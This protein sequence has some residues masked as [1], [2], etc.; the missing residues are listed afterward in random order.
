MTVNATPRE[1][2]MELEDRVTR[3][4]KRLRRQN[5]QA[6]LAAFAMG[7]V[8]LA[9]SAWAM[10]GGGAVSGG[11]DDGLV[12]ARQFVLQDAEGRTRG[13]W[14]V[15]EDGT[16]RIVLSDPSGAQRMMLSV[17]GMEGSPG[18][19]LSDREGNRRIVLGLLADQSSNIVIADADGT[20][21]AVLGMSGEDRTDLILADRLGRTRVSLGVD[22]E[23]GSTMVVPTEP[24]PPADGN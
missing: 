8:A 9:A 10:Y 7:I 3:D 17:L 1:L 23:G 5:T 12:A 15:E 24:P 6:M 20:P 18:L 21:R 19:S 14:L 4:L 16:S 22:A 11:G 13:E 2:V